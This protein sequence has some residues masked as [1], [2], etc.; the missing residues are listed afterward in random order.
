MSD[1]PNYDSLSQNLDPVTL[2]PIY[3][4]ATIHDFTTAVGYQLPGTAQG[5]ATTPSGQPINFYIPPPPVSSN[6]PTPSP[7]TDWRSYLPYIIGIVTIL[8]LLLIY[9]FIRR[10]SK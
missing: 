7:Q 6:V 5:S 2:L 4:T 8:L 9:Y 1:L 10:N 3:G